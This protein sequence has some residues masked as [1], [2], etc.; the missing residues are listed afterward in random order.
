MC[1]VRHL[2][3]VAPLR[4]PVM[5]AAACAF[6]STLRRLHQSNSEGSAGGPCD[7]SKLQQQQQQP[8]AMPPAGASCAGSRS[9]MSGLLHMIAQRKETG[10]KNKKEAP[11]A[12]NGC[13]VV[14]ELFT[15]AAQRHPRSPRRHGV[16]APRT[17]AEA[18]RPAASPP[19]PVGARVVSPTL[20]EKLRQKVLCKQLDWQQ[21]LGQQPLLQRLPVWR[22]R[23][24]WSTRFL[25]SSA[26]PLSG[27]GDSSGATEVFVCSAPTGTG[28]SSLVPLFLLDSHWRRLLQRIDATH[29]PQDG[30]RR[31]SESPPPPM[32]LLP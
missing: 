19:P 5:F 25:S 16:A 13:T 29:G 24:V 27:G 9:S 7:H 10:R 18:S 20:V 6:Y 2:R 17:D 3:V 31:A 22:Q 4:P 14:A 23:S 11:P 8:A 30:G 28:K 1:A 32:L 12:K 26:L 15:S 21:M